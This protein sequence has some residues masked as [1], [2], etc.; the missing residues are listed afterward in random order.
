MKIAFIKWSAL[1][2]LSLS[3]VFVYAQTNQVSFKLGDKA[4]PLKIIKW[5][6]GEP[7]AKFKEGRLYAVE[8]GAVACS[9][10]RKNIPHL[11]DLAKKYSKDL[12]IVSI[13][14]WESNKE[15]TTNLLYLERI[16]ALVAELDS[17]IGFTVAADVPQQSTA[18][19]WMK[20]SDQH[21]IPRIFLIDRSGTLAWI[22]HPKE[23]DSVI[24]K[25]INGKFDR[26]Y[27]ST[28][29]IERQESEKK[30]QVRVNQILQAKEKGDLQASITAIDSLIN[31]NPNNPWFY[32]IKFKVFAGSDDENANSLARWM[33]DNLQ[34]FDWNYM[35]YYYDLCKKPDYNL[36]IEITERAIESAETQ[37]IAA[38][39]LVQKAK[40]LGLKG[41]L[42]GAVGTSKQ[43]LEFGK[44]G[45][46][47]ELKE[48]QDNFN[49]WNNLSRTKEN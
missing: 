39:L 1:I 18:D 3:L 4:P 17:Q 22:G 9:P 28:R 16:K 47:S 11:S 36:A 10:C 31:A 41:D 20:S 48:F 46:P 19:A 21:S 42:E 12:T 13:F 29:Q 5:F 30:I 24:Y 49:Y 45:V 26:N 7:I 34:N 27:E 33:L 25:I 2:V 38:Y 32:N 35:V 44:T 14:T 37:L 40:F 8:F 6:K 23:L 43:A 15:D